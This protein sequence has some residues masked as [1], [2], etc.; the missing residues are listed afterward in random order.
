MYICIHV[1]KKGF[2]DPFSRNVRVKSQFLVHISRLKINPKY[3]QK[4]NQHV[5]SHHIPVIRWMEEI[6]HQLIDGLCHYL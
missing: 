1:K 6:L 5:F 4:K 2:I 3:L